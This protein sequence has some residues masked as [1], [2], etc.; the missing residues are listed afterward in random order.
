MKLT[1]SHKSVASAMR[2]YIAGERSPG[3][4]DAKTW[5][6]SGPDQQL[7]PLKHVMA[8]AS[9]VPTR[10]FNT[11]DAR[12]AAEKLGLRTVFAGHDLLADLAEIQQTGRAKSTTFEQLILARLGQGTFRNALLR[13]QSRCF[14]TA[15]ADCQL[16][17]ASHIKPWAHSSDKERLDHKNGILLIPQ[18]DRAFDRGLISFEDNGRILVSRSLLDPEKI[19]IHR[20]M[21][22]TATQG[23]EAFLS[24]HRSNVFKSGR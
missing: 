9:R 5:F 19:G 4:R 10:D 15:Y 23:R 14:V 7:L 6:V 20:R 13:E 16:L 18:L 12:S 3:A 11:A 21:R 17:V 22:L 1:L 24:Y 2:S 8:L